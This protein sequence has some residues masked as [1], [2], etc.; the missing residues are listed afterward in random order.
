MTR[1]TNG[2][3]PAAASL[4]REVPNDTGPV[5]GPD[6]PAYV[7]QKHYTP[8]FLRIYDTLVLRI[9]GPL[10]WRCPTRRL[11]QE[12][13]RHVGGRH[14]D[15]GPG[16]GY[17]IDRAGLRPDTSVTLLDPN[18][19]VLAYASRR[20]SRFAPA[21]VQADVCAGIPGEARFDSI[22]LNYV[23]HCLRGPMSAKATAIASVARALEP[24]GVLFGA[25]VLGATA[26]HSWLSRRA[27]WENNRKGIFSN[28]EDSAQGLRVVLQASFAA[29]EVQVVGTVAVFHASG[30]VS[31]P[32]G[33]VTL[34]VDDLSSRSGSSR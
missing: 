7:G 26:D 2:R 9:F 32:S 27:L 1:Q 8:G 23:L 30:P 15:I 28:M 17:L 14:L 21:L 6:H 16:T 24:R 12:Y 3:L 19:H 18:P 4:T 29:H 25:T 22:A 31:S 20:L 34:A 5:I 33:S 13:E 11:V 10:I